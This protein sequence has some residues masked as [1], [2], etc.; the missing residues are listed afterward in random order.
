M[1]GYYGMDSSQWPSANNPLGPGSPTLYQ[2][3]LTGG[4]PTSPST[5]LHTSLEATQV[6]GQPVYLLHWNS[7]PGLTY[8]VQ[9]SSDMVNWTDYQSPRFAA[10]VI[11]SVQ[12]PDNNLQ[13][14]RLVRLR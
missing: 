12:V 11:D 4:D 1:A 3:Y 2:I 13:Y 8:Q 9:T 10:D 5:W 6:N 7:Q 14:Y